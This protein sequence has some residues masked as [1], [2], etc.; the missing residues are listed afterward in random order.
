MAALTDLSDI[1][2]RLTGGNSGTPEHLP[3]WIDGRIQAA[4]AVATI[5]ARMT[6][7]WRYNKSNGGNGATPGAAAIPTRATLGALGQANPGGGRQKWLMGVQ[8]LLNA[9]GILV[10]YDRLLHNGG[11]SGTV[12]TAQTVGGGPVNRYAGALS[13]GNQIW[14]EIYT[15]IG[16]TGT[17][18]TASYTNQASTAGRTTKA[19]AIGATG[20]RE[21]SRIIPLT[22]QDGDTGV[23]DVANCTVLATTGTAGSFGIT[24]ARPLII[25][26]CGGAGFPATRDLL[27]G[28]PSIAELLTDS[29][30]AMAW[31]ANGTTVPQG[32]LIPS[33][34]EK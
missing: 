30:I 23:E 29:A 17:T 10:I 4:A 3:H 1:A 19:V 2:N 8:A 11:L 34:I 25:V 31:F 27:A 33:M 24:I 9:P 18:I 7:L 32:M 13:I 6:S 28:L 21:E 20:L 12:T 14:V 22:L 26:S 5:A 16:A 15:Q